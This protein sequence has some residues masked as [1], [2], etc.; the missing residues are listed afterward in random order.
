MSP[1][2][3]SATRTAAK[4][5]VTSPPVPGPG[6]SGLLQRRCACGGALGPSGECVAC[7]QKRLAG[8]ILQ[9]KLRVNQPGD[10]FEQEADRVAEQVMRMPAPDVQRQVDEEEEEELLQTKPRIQ[11]QVTGE[12]NGGSAAPPIVHEVLR[13]SGRPLDSSTRSFMEARFGHDFSQVR[14]HADGKAAASAQAVNARAFTVGR[15]VVFGPGEYAPGSREGQRLLAH[16]LVHVVQQEARCAHLQRVIEIRPPGRGEAS[17]FDR[18]QE[19]IDRLNAQSPAIQYWL[20]GRRLRYRI[21][22][23]SALTNFDHQM[24]GFIDRPE[25]VP[26]RLITR[27]GYVGGGP[28]L[29]DSLVLA[30]V[31]L[32]DLLA[33][34][35]LSF[36]LNLIHLLTERF[37]VRGYARRI[38]TAM[39]EFDRVHRAGLEAEA[40]HLQ[41]VIGDPSIRFN[42]EEE[43]PNGTVVFAFRSS[44]GYRVFHVFRAAG[45]EE[46]HGVIWV[47]TR[48]GRRLTVEQ[49]RQERAGRVERREEAFRFRWPG[50]DV[51][52]FPRLRLASELELHLDPEIQAQINAMRMMQD[53]LNP[54]RIRSSLLRIDFS[55]L[56]ATQPP[57]WLTGPPTPQPAPLVPRGAGPSTPRA[58]TPGD[59]VR[60]ILAIPAVDAALTRLRTQAEDRLRR[61]WRRLSTGERVLLVSQAALIT[62]TALAGVLSDPE[63]RQFTLGLIQNRD[64]PIPGVPGLTFQ[65]NVTGRDRRILF[66]LNLGALLPPVLGFR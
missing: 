49:L 4:I 15:D 63:A 56:L 45:R 46:R 55:T 64:I 16:E 59:V 65:F 33:S 36:Q 44:E 27:S 48:D 30:Y 24:R 35:D 29:V 26:M 10:P 31:D 50:M 34:G 38:G 6:R 51:S 20:E 52:P 7:Q 39:P 57:P 1:Q 54:D 22:D 21:V 41:S 62:G 32:D 3:A 11:H 12:A 17:A 61:D 13:S 5:A 53:L 14:V 66:N 43:R 18:R 28:L 40:A 19:L 42:Y 2:A 8:G 37:G 58:G 9:T 47:R 23:E 25:V 60:A